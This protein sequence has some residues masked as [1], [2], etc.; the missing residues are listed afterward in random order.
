M[1]WICMGLLEPLKRMLISI[2]NQLREL[3]RVSLSWWTRLVH[4]NLKP[5]G[6]FAMGKKQKNALSPK[7]EATTS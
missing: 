4:D 6:H 5:S 7:G 3:S 1:L 2:V